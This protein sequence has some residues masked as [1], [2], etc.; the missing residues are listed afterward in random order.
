[1]YMCNTKDKTIKNVILRCGG[2]GARQSYGDFMEK[3]RRRLT[4]QGKGRGFKYT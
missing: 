2:G 4:L 3:M 1:M